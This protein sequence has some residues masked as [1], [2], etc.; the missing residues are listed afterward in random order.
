PRGIGPAARAAP[1]GSI[2]ARPHRASPAPPREPGPAARELAAA[3][4]E[5]APAAPGG[6]LRAIAPLLR[7]AF[8]SG[9]PSAPATRQ[10][11]GL[12][13]LRTARSGRG[14]ASACCGPPSACGSRAPRRPHF[15]SQRKNMGVSFLYWLLSLVWLRML[16]RRRPFPRRLEP[17]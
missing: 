7:F 3:P 4:G 17:A 14:L 15:L 13:L 2:G 16:S 12:G 10:R 6:G 5:I 1:P 11:A 8:S 9:K